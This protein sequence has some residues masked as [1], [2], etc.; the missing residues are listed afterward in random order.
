MFK[1]KENKKI[2]E[3]N[4]IIYKTQGECAQLKRQLEEKCINERNLLSIQAKELAYEFIKKRYDESLA[5]HFTRTFFTEFQDLLS[6][7]DATKSN[8]TSS[9]KQQ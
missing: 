1:K 9:S 4:K 3:L 6:N 2:R 7:F 5:A 8:Q